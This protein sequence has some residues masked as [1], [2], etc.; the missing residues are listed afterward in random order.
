MSSGRNNARTAGLLLTLGLV[1][2]SAAWGQLEVGQ[3]TS[4]TLTGDL[5][6]G[7]AGNYTSP[8]GGSSHGTSLNGDAILQGYYYN[9]KFLTFFVDP[10]Y[11]RSQANSGQGSITDATSVNAG[12]NLFTGSHFPGAVTF[13]E[14]FNSS[15][16]YGFGATPGITTTGNSH[17]FSV[18]W[19]ELIPGAPP[20]NAQY[21]Q[22]ASSS[23]IFGSDQR[24]H[25]NTKNFNV[26][27]NYKLDGWYMGARFAD[28]WTSTELPSA[29]T[30]GETVTGDTNAKIFSFNAN[31]KL[32][33]RGSFGG[34]YSWADFGG[35]NNGNSVT[36]SNQLVSATASFT[37]TNR[38]TTS[39]QA[40]YD[41][42]VSGA[43]EQQLV[44]A[45]SIAPQVNLGTSGYSIALSNFDNYSI[46]KGLSL[47]FS[48]GHIQQVVYGETV[49]ATHF[50][51]LLN[52]RFLKPLW[53][54]VVVYAGVNDQASEA[55]NQGAGLV[56]GANFTK[57]WT[58]FDLG[59]SFAYSQDT[60]TILALQTT[61]EL[62]VP[63]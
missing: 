8:S 5:G 54:T 27:S 48:V 59:G 52:Y 56:A 17:G 15:G 26:F 50:S 37:P 33:L 18:G 49:S 60:Q 6:Y 35:E 24:D 57:Q 3:Y 31:H 32:P 46:G 2:A 16:N 25:S 61:F 11:N 9:P 45:G 62:F 21:T 42:N 36:G 38:I 14:A 4:M 43:I 20:V 40:N 34:S 10:I 44:G 19:S 29:I 7:Y 63:G 53:G 1:L 51:G 22:S 39:F 23:S 28:T 30:G 47:G 55:G 41:T 12:V 58:N 13:G